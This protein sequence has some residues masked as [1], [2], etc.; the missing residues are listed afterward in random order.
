MLQQLGAEGLDGI[1]PSF[2]STQ[3]K[4]AVGEALPGRERGVSSFCAN[5]ARSVHMV[6]N[7]ICSGYLGRP[8]IRCGGSADIV[9][10]IWWISADAVAQTN[11]IDVASVERLALEDQVD[12]SLGDVFAALEF[13]PLPAMHPHKVWRWRQ[14]LV[15]F[16]TPSFGD[17]K[18]LR[19]LPALGVSVQS[20]H[21]LNYLIADPLT[22]A[23]PY[24]DGAL[25]QIPRPERYAF[26]K[27]IVSERRRERGD[28]QKARKDRAQVAFLIRVLAEEDPYALFDAWTSPGASEETGL[29]HGARRGHGEVAGGSRKVKRIGSGFGERGG[30]HVAPGRHKGRGTI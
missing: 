2:T 6:V 15:E 26:H 11:D 19:D 28:A 23:L 22:V 10:G 25:I 21:F 14:T 12:P 5:P 3:V 29:V 20:L 18:G 1:R 30:R 13:E 4:R 27:L 24:R 9:R 16:V 7:A 8:A 17:D